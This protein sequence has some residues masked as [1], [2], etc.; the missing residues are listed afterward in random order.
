MAPFNSK[1][2]NLRTKLASVQCHSSC[3]GQIQK[4]IYFE[5]VL[6]ENQDTGRKKSFCNSAGGSQDQ[7]PWKFA[8]FETDQKHMAPHEGQAPAHPR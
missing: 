6:V 3:C 1:F 7:V 5:H 8:I 2:I 4:K